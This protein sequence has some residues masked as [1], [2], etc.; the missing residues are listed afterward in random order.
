MHVEA[1][2]PAASG[3]GHGIEMR[4]AELAMLLDGVDLES[5]QRRPRYRRPTTATAP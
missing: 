2:G 3:E 1:T 5:V 4:A